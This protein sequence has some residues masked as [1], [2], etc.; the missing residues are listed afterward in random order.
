[1]RLSRYSILSA[2]ALACAVPG[3][4]AFA[5]DAA[6]GGIGAPHP[7]QMGMRPAF[8]P[9][10]EHVHALHNEL[11]VIL[12]LVALLVLVLLG[13]VIYRFNERRNPTASRTSHNAVI[14][15]LWTVLPVII[16]VIIAIPSFKLLYYSDRTPQAELTIK[17]I[18]HQWYW[19]YEYPDN[20]NF[21]F[22]ANLVGD[23][24]L[25]PGQLRLLTTDNHLV[26]PVDTNIRLLVT[27]T[28]VIHSWF[29]PNF[30]VKLDAV[31]GRVN[32]TWFR[33]NQEGV[34]YGQCSQLCGIHHAFMPIMLEAMSKDKFKA[35]VDQAKTKFA[36]IEQPVAAAPKLAQAPAD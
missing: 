33:A 36:A 29:M 27:A 11:L 5:Q 31:P 14:E 35:W 15:V 34:F 30:A 18:G 7:W 2:L 6:G 24:D 28:D 16:L 12:T 17:A 26:V 10:A 1:M 25:K 32:E 3:G 19:S 20:G 21:T 22:D 8:S 13:Y 4:R 9:V 23:K